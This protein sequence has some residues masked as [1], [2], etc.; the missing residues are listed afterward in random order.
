M[1][2]W[3]LWDHP[4]LYA[5]EDLLTF[6]LFLTDEMAEEYEISRLSPYYLTLRLT[7]PEGSTVLY[8]TSILKAKRDE[9]YM[10]YETIGNYPRNMPRYLREKLAAH[11]GW[12]YNLKEFRE[13]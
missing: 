13:A 7:G 10:L 11:V 1:Q 9:R 8:S 2:P 5:T 6:L 3:D 12:F 4:Y